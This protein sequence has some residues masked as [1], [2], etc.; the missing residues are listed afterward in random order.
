MRRMT[1]EM[2]RFLD[3]ELSEAEER[4]ILHRFAEDPEARAML[5]FDAGLRHVLAGGVASDDRVVPAGFTNR[6]MAAIEARE[7][8][9]AHHASVARERRRDSATG[10][11]RRALA[12]L[13]EELTRPRTLT[14]RPA[15]ALA[16]TAVAA[17]VLVIALGGLERLPGTGSLAGGPET[18]GTAG[19]P[20]AAAVTASARG[21]AE[22]VLV[23]FV[24]AEEAAESVAVAG[25]FSD[26]EPIPLASRW[27]GD[28]QMWSGVVAVPR[29]EHRYMFV[30]DGERW[31]TDPLATAQRDDGFGHRNAILSL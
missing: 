3:G 9:A 29:G 16:A 25:D 21:G 18:E 14:W 28:R 24:L 20:D 17:L 4:E 13:W 8:E 15:H 12:G 19:T 27:S 11:G 22:T 10:R 7:V 5:R 1:E 31:V 2:A 23:R 30:L 26:W 6:V